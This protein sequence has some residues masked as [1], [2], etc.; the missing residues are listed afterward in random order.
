MCWPTRSWTPCWA[1]R[2]W[3]TSAKHFPDTAEEYAGADSLMLA[4]RVAEIMTEHGWRIE[5]IDAT[6][7]CQ[8]P[9][10]APNIPAMRA[11]LAEASGCRWML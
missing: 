3:A 5:N 7:L 11:K 2:R 4:R 6:I 8:R 1:Q 10:L 9:K